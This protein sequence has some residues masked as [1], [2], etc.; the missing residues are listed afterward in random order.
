MNSI[1]SS[2][3]FNAW[4]HAAELVLKEGT[5]IFDDSQELVELLHL[6]ITVNNPRIDE[7]LESVDAR[8]HAWM[9]SN[10]QDVKEVPELGH[11]KSYGWRLRNYNG[12]DQVDWVVRKLRSKPAT[13][14]ATITTL[15]PG[16][17]TTY[18]PCV[19]LLDFKLREGGLLLTVT[20]RSLDL[21]KKALF[22]MME[23]TRLGREIAD[24][25]GAGLRELVVH[26]ISGHIYTEDIQRVRSI[27]DG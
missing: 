8:M 25:V 4:K 6:C 1:H 2:T 21:G 10:F 3:L 27:L 15:V 12:L 11:A 17:D 5:T 9:R 19:S 20:C 16:G 22:N 24:S 23:L 18:V 26:V 13:K 14:S 7:S